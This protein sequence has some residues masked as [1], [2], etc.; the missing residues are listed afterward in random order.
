MKKPGARSSE[1][2]EVLEYWLQDA[3]I[4][5][6]PSRPLTDVWWGGGAERD[7]AIEVSFGY[8]V[9]EAIAGGLNDW[10]TH[11]LDRLALVLLLDQFTRNIFRGQS[12]AFAGDA[13][14]QALVTSALTLGWDDTL[15]LAGRAFFYMPLTHSEN[16]TLQDEGV[17]CFELLLQGAHAS[18]S[19]DI[20]SFLTSAKQHRDIISTFGR[21]PHRN[22]ALGRIDAANE[23]DYLLRGPRFGQ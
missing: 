1:A 5:G 7:D 22:A 23:Q 11:P 10:E 17:H 6:W 13:R 14:A 19:K 20:Q 21:F 2:A 9:R 12:K 15:A 16:M 3:L 18:R 8:L 4:L